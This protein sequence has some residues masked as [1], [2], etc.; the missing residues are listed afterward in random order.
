[1]SGTA[2]SRAQGAWRTTSHR[3]SDSAK[4]GIETQATKNNVSKHEN[5]FIVAVSCCFNYV[6]SMIKFFMDC[7]ISEDSQITLVAIPRLQLS[8]GRGNF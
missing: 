4:A 8:L 3:T 5:N 1:M 2:L 7:T 6:Y